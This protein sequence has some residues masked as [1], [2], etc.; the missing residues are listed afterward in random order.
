MRLI[1][2]SDL[3]LCSE[4]DESCR[5][6]LSFLREIPGAKDTLI[7][8]GDIFDLV[9]GNKKIYRKSFPGFFQQ[10]SS[11]IKGGTQIYYLE[12]NHDFHLRGLLP[13]EVTLKT[14]DFTVEWGGKKIWIT[15]G[16]MID[17]EDHGYRILRG[18]TR[19]LPF[20]VLLKF[21]PGSAVHLIGAWSSRQSRKR[22]D[23]YDISD[24]R[25]RRLRDLFY[26]FSMNRI[27]NGYDFVLAGH[28]HLDDQKHL[29]AGGRKG[30][31]LNL[32]FSRLFLPYAILT[33]GAQSFTVKRYP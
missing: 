9:I 32:G 8:G 22:H 24:E 5:R 19:S 7:L 13:P 26:T 1:Y 23:V 28:S 33:E 30:E 20:K 29:A 31:Y 10:V 17:S 2:L 6:F 21:I 27:G 3:H 25:S 12:G 4:A 14:D 16:D 11:L 18:I 15:H